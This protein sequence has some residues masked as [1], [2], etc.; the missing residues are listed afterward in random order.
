MCTQFSEQSAKSEEK[1]HVAR[2]TN[3][4]IERPIEIMLRTWKTAYIV[5]WMHNSKAQ[6]VF[7][8]HTVKAQKLFASFSGKSTGWIPTTSSER[9]LGSYNTKAWSSIR[10]ESWRS[11]A[12]L[13]HCLKSQSLRH[14]KH[15]RMWHALDEKWLFAR[16]IL[17]PTKE[18]HGGPY[19]HSVLEM[20]PR[21]TV[22]LW[23][24]GRNSWR[25]KS[26]WR[27]PSVLA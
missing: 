14:I 17:A 11:S 7:P 27:A 26:S 12:F 16:C 10:F 8:R 21:N 24:C 19:K 5:L 9:V 15:G 2:Q 18:Y 25:G 13:P 20:Y 6:R 3:W 23:Q 1:L 22:D 4:A